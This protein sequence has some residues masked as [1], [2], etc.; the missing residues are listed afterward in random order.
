MVRG[1][2]IFQQRFAAYVDQYVLHVEVLT[3]AF[4]TAFWQFVE[5]GGYEIRQ[6]SR[7]RRSH[8][9]N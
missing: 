5:E 9:W 6:A 2:K 8:G 7:S 1:L 4:G 3:P